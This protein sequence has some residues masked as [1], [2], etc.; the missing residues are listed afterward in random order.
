MAAFAQL[1][2]AQTEPIS[3]TVTVVFSF[4]FPSCSYIFVLDSLAR[5]EKA[6]APANIYRIP[7]PDGGAEFQQATIGT[8]FGYLCL[9]IVAYPLLAVLVER[10]VHGVS[11]RRRSFKTNTKAADATTALEI[12][13]LVKTYPVSWWRRFCCCCCGKRARPFVAVDSLDFSSQKQQILCLLGINGSGK[14]TTMDLIT[15][16]QTISGGNIT[17][18]AAASQIGTLPVILRLQCFQ[19]VS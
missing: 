16:R 18:N 9:S 6:S 7:P 11:M 14:T 13:G 10:Y 3:A 4:L 12:N 17:I 19:P 5:F 15:G 8:L 2:D 1:L